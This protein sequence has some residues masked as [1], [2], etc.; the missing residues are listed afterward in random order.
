[1]PGIFKR[2]QWAKRE[3]VITWGKKKTL[4]GHGSMR[5]S[6]VATRGGEQKCAGGESGVPWA[7]WGESGEE[8]ARNRQKKKKKNCADGANGLR[9]Q[10]PNQTLIAERRGSTKLASLK[11][12][13]RLKFKEKQIAPRGGGKRIWVTY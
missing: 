7:L 13:R 6:S 4:V 9:K 2:F 3:M 12:I 5:E 11:K 1:V 8:Q 10:S